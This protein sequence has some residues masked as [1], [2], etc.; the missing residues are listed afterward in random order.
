MILAWRLST[1]METE[2]CLEVL[3]E[4]VAK[5]GV[6]AIFNT[7]CGSQFQSREFIEAL[8]GYGIEISNDGVGRC[9]D[10][11]RVERTWKTIK[12]EFIFLYDW[13]C[14]KDLKEGLASFIDSYNKK[15]SHEALGY[16]TPYEVYSN[17]CFPRMGDSQKKTEVA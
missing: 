12:Y 1:K 4:A 7:D 10:N 5:Y 3:H 15:R 6:P 13:K 2:F 8:K 17:G 14:F 9:L 16:Q 11:I